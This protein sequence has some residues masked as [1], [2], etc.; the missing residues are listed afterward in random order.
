MP[1][2]R[3]HARHT[4]NEHEVSER[5][6]ERGPNE[7]VHTSYATCGWRYAPLKWLPPPATASGARGRG[8]PPR[9]RSAAS[10][11]PPPPPHCRPH[12]TSGIKIG[13]LRRGGGCRTTLR[14]WRPRRTRCGA[15]SE[16][17]C[18]CCII[19]SLLYSAL[20]G[21]WGTP[22]KEKCRKERHHYAPV[23]REDEESGEN[24]PAI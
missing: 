13:S 21:R 19:R 23:M 10:V 6:G 5:E 20:A 3:V 22:E 7:T 17:S 14:R 1:A 11:T 18:C 9:A 16:E 8:R 24:I 15:S 4:G 2:L 12:R